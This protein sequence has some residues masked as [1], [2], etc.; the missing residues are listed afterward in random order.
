MTPRD[1]AATTLVVAALALC[2]TPAGASAGEAPG[3]GVAISRAEALREMDAALRKAFPTKE[4][5][6]A[7]LVVREGQPIVRRGY[8]LAD[9]ENAVPMG[10]DGVFRVG[11]IGC[12]FT[13]VAI[14]ML[15]EEGK[16]RLGDP[17]ESHVAGW[18]THGRTITLDQLLGHTSGIPD[19][20][21]RSQ[22]AQGARPARTRDELLAEVRELPLEFEPGTRFAWSSS[23]YLL[24]G[25]VIE[26]V[27]GLSY[28][29]F[30]H[31]RIAVPL[32]LRGTGCEDA[33][34][35]VPRRVR[36]YEIGG[37]KV[38]N[39][40]APAAVPDS[41]GGLL[42]TVDDL[43]A[44]ES[45]LR[46]GKLVPRAALA[47][48][49]TPGVLADGTAT[50][51]GFGWMV[52][53]VERRPSFEHGGGTAG[54]EAYLLSIPDEGLTVAVLTN[55]QGGSP[56][57]GDVAMEIASYA[58]GRRPRTPRA[59]VLTAR[60]LDRLAGVYGEEGDARRVVRRQGATLTLEG[61]EPPL[62]LI[63]LGAGVFGTPEARRWRAR[64]TKGADGVSASLRITPVVGPDEVL[65]R[66]GPVPTERAGPAS[67][68][69]G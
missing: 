63:A 19:P 2:A 33:R 4:P 55:R 29:E 39:A 65:P 13:A 18:P 9:V 16:L 30:L 22:L 31:Q 38:K 59:V 14:L 24:L 44:W 1:R 64:F 57:P 41:G 48:A 35:V 45:A 51:Y 3:A 11:A 43:A 67:S 25:L 58:L 53:E 7:V 12:Q 36:G 6:A 46:A 40:Q 62:R 69:G 52:S 56:G 37:G 23:G 34:A 26:K 20:P 21:D 60:E 28:C 47:L 49:R 54:F 17:I 66:E 8:G 5:G 32:G 42:S 68:P 10:V 61:R 15:A 27:S 50:R